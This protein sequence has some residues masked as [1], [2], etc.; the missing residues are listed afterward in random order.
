MGQSRWLPLNSSTNSQGSGFLD[1]SDVTDTLAK[2]FIAANDPRIQG[3]L[4]DVDGQLLS[5][6]Q[7]VDVTLT[8]ISI[9]LHF[10]LLKYARA[11][12][13]VACFEDTWGA[14]NNIQTDQETIKKKLDDYRKEMARL[15]LN[16]TYE[17]F[18]YTNLSLV[19][20]QRAGGTI[21]LLRG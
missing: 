1:I 19:G 8:S 15:A 2:R 13:C 17:M 11:A 4:D 12:F 21:S 20:K 14:N 10:V 9:P 7:Q 18:S 3:W 5:L 16:C 6:A